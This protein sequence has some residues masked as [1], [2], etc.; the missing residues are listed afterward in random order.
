MRSNSKL[1][2][3]GH[4]PYCSSCGKDQDE[5]AVHECKDGKIAF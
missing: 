4:E 5:W 3:V 1:E 2:Y